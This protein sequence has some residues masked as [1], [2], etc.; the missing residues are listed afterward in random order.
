MG[1][2][3]REIYRVN[4]LINNF[5]FLGKPIV[6]NREWISSDVLIKDVLYILKDKIPNGIEIQVRDQDDPVPL[7]C[8][9]VYMRICL[10]NLILNSV[11]AIEGKGAVVVAFGKTPDHCTISVRDNGKGIGREDLEKIYE[12]YFSTKKLGIGLGLAV[13]KR[14]V[15]EHGGR[16]TIESEE[17]KGAMTLIEVPHHE[18]GEG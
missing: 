9:R 12:P 2:L 17:G 13:T 8:D 1:G 7:Y 3:T 14:L 15:E 16:I 5:L 4:E 10:I 18:G 6:L 11:Q